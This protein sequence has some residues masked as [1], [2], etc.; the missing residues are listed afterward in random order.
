V[1]RPPPTTVLTRSLTTVSSLT[2]NHT[3]HE[4]VR[5]W[6]EDDVT[7]YRIPRMPRPSGT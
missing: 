7:G 6:N 4:A 3:S 5:L 2:N 1:V